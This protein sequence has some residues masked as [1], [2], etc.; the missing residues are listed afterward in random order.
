MTQALPVNFRSRYS[1]WWALLCTLVLHALLLLLLALL[2]LG[3][4]V[5]SKLD[6]EAGGMSV[7]LGIPEGVADVPPS[8]AE[9]TEV[10]VPLPNSPNTTQ[11]APVKTQPVATQETEAAP[12]LPSAPTPKPM[13]PRMQRLL[14]RQKSN[15]QATGTSAPSKGQVDGSQGVAA[16]GISGQNGFSVSGDGLETRGFTRAPDPET[17]RML[18]AT[19]MIPIEVDLEGNVRIVGSIKS[20]KPLNSNQKRILTEATLQSRFLR[21]ALGKTQQRGYLTYQLQVKN[22]N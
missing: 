16:S 11:P 15:T 18:D 20:S 19:V 14:E 10:P 4:P 6:S 8:E 7:A 12:V 22:K 17:F 21:S 9:A 1:S 3:I 13:D 2:R 5:P